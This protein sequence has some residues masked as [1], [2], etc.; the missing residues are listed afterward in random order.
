MASSRYTVSQV[1][2]AIEKSKS[3]RQ[4]CKEIGLKYAGGNV[5]TMKNIACAHD[6]NFSHFLGQGWNMGGEP[7]NEMPPEEVFVKDSSY[8]SKCGLKKK[9]LKYNLL[10][11]KCCECKIE[12]EWESKPLQLHLDHINADTLDNRIENLRFLCP[13]CHSQTPTYCRRNTDIERKNYCSKCGRKIWRKN[14]SRVC[15]KCQ[16]NLC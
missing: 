11:Y 13:N 10:K 1:G 5:R 14:A 4:V 8:I 7:L 16:Q 9:I 12:G 15:I 6:F 2:E 3:W